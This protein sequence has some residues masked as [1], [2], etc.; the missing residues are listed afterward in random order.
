M[1]LCNHCK[2][3]WMEPELSQSMGQDKQ[4][5]EKDIKIKRYRTIA[6]IYPHKSFEAELEIGNI[7]VYVNFDVDDGVRMDMDEVMHSDSVWA[8]TVPITE[9]DANNEDQEVVLSETEW[10][11]VIRQMLE[12]WNA[13]PKFVNS[14][15]WHDDV[16]GITDWNR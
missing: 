5:V 2:G 6:E 7:S 1:K 13:N 3:E 16:S 4:N 15:K 14:S 12:V 11:L 8:Y 10:E 9:V